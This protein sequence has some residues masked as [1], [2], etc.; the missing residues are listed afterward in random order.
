[1]N[2]TTVKLDALPRPFDIFEHPDIAEGDRMQI[3]ALNIDERQRSL[4]LDL[5][6]GRAAKTTKGVISHSRP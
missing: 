3:T 1:M 4:R 5:A 6:Y 2:H